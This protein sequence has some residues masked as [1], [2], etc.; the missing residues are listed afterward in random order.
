MARPYPLGF[1]N[2]E[3]VF[4]AGLRNFKILGHFE[5][6]TQKIEKV[7]G[8]VFAKQQVDA[9]SG[10]PVADDLFRKSWQGKT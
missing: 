1:D 6:E 2:R 10:Q 9:V 5:C 3:L 8:L 7:L 4:F